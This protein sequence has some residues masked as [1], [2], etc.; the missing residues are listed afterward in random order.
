MGLSGFIKLPKWNWR[1][2]VGQF[3]GNLD[4][5]L[6]LVGN[7]QHMSTGHVFSQ[8][9]VVFDDLCETVI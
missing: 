2:C 7:V 4:E 5:H 8:F 9:H 6:P 3:L 1:A